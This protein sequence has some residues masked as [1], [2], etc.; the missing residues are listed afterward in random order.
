MGW[1]EQLAA[2]E[3][4]VPGAE[5]IDNWEK[6]DGEAPFRDF[7]QSYLGWAEYVLRDPVSFTTEEVLEIAREGALDEVVT[8]LSRACAGCEE[9]HVKIDDATVEDGRLHVRIEYGGC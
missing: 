1:R 7:G 6:I 4:V 2:G 5:N 8:G 3:S 9:C